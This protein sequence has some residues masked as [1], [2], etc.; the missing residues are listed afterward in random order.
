MACKYS[1]RCAVLSC[2]GVFLI[3][4]ALAVTAYMSACTNVYSDRDSAC[5][6]ANDQI[7]GICQ[8]C[9]NVTSA[10]S[11][12]D[13]N[14]YC[15]IDC[16]DQQKKLDD[17]KCPT[18]DTGIGLIVLFLAVAAIACVAT[19]WYMGRETVEALSRAPSSVQE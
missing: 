17:M 15:G 11:A 5:H 18:H 4:A 14:L 16:A 3:A 12:Q 6:Q 2:T 19:I 13:V 7:C 8:R 9:S 10:C 1:R